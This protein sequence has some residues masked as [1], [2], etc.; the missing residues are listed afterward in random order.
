M[1]G[2]ETWTLASDTKKRL[3]SCEMWFLRRMMKTPWTDRVSN[4]EVLT[5]AGVQRKM[6]REMLIIGS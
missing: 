1:Y 5:R 2:S 6:I 4:E 3:E